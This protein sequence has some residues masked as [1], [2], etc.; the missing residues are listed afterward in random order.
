MSFLRA[1]FTR[2]QSSK[3]LLAE[4][5]DKSVEVYDADGELK[6]KADNVMV[7]ALKPDSKKAKHVQA[8]QVATQ[9]G[10]SP[11]E[12]S[13]QLKINPVTDQGNDVVKDW[14]F[15]YI[16]NDAQLEVVGQRKCSKI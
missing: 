5:F 12:F 16:S 9:Q 8:C 14:E 1:L 2:K 6:L 3:G 4:Y 10:F 11:Y 13:H 15:V 7:T